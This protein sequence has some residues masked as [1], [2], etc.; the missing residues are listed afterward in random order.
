MFN[1]TKIR[2]TALKGAMLSLSGSSCLCLLS[3]TG[4]SLGLLS[5]IIIFLSVLRIGDMGRFID[6]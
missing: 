1:W 4:S 2:I 3:S 6:F 5:S